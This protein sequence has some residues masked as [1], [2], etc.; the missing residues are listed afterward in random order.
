MPKVGR[1]EFIKIGIT[2]AGVAVLAGYV[3]YHSVKPKEGSI[4][5]PS[6]AYTA[7][8]RQIPLETAGAQMVS[9][10]ELLPDATQPLDLNRQTDFILFAMNLYAEALPARNLTTYEKYGRRPVEAVAQ[11]V[12]NRTKYHNLND[13]TKKLFGATTRETILKPSQFSWTN[14]SGN[15]Y[16][17]AFYPRGNPP[18]SEQ[19]GWWQACLDIT[20]AALNGK[21]AD[22]GVDN[23]DHYFAPA[24]IAPNWADESKFVVELGA[25]RFYRLY[26]PPSPK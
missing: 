11:V 2:A 7:E 10:P 3:A 21:M 25:H 9:E 23:A 20:D 19:E 15:V 14:P 24:K 8:L 16:E 4:I 1:R 5:T 18:D 26:C 13:T 6:N 12:L 22:P 17:A